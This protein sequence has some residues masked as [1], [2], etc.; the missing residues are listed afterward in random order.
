MKFIYFSLLTVLLV[1]SSCR[2]QQ[3]AK[4]FN[5]FQKSLDSVKA[6][7]YKEPVIQSGDQ[8]SIQL[9]SNTLSQEQAMVFNLANTTGTTDNGASKTSSSNVSGAGFVVD[10]EGNI[11]YPLVG[12][13]KAKGLTKSQLAKEIQNKVSVYVK[14]PTAI[15]KMTNF[16]V[17]VLGEVKSPGVILLKEDKPTLL[18]AIAQSGD[19]TDQGERTNIIL[20]RETNGERKVYNINLTDASIFNEEYFQLQQNDVIYVQANKQKLY[21]VNTNTIEDQRKIQIFQLGLQILTSVAL[22]LNIYFQL[23]RN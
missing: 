7:Q 6:Y 11:L 1:A 3:P 15:I 17:N 13:I 4:N 21:A 19:L 18:D 22:L 12:K 2:V 14:D 16:K 5:Y 20:V 9:I 23:R 8:L 10:S